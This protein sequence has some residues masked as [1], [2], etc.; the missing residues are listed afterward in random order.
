M[1]EKYTYSIHQSGYITI[2]DLLGDTVAVIDFNE[3]LSF[4][5]AVSSVVRKEIR[6]FL[7][8]N[9]IAYFL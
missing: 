5:K 2:R 4:T 6:D 7:D 8:L 9:D 3:R 1:T